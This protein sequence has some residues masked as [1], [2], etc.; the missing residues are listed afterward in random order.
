MKRSRDSFAVRSFTGPA[1]L[2]YLNDLAALRIEVFREFPYLYDGNM[3]SER[4]YLQAFLAAPDAVLVIAFDGEKVI[5]ASTGLPMI[6][7]TP[8]IQQ[9]FLE[10]GYDIE[11]VFYYGESVLKKAYRGKGLGLAFFEHRE[12]HAR[13]LGQFDWVCFCGVI[14]P[15]DH[16]RRPEDY[17]PLDD[18]WQKRGFERTEMICNISWQDLDEASES[19][20]TLRFWKK[21]L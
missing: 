2:D 5:G 1:A 9:P 13:K 14:R 8:N 20:K 4:A 7:E 6:H 18:F 11:K 15:E 12:A 19:P 3:A 10:A 21:R 17:V 16:P